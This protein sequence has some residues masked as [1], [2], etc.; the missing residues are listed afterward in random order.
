MNIFRFS[1]VFMLFLV[2]SINVGLASAV[3]ATCQSGCYQVPQLLVEPSGAESKM[4]FANRQLKSSK[5][6]PLKLFTVY[7]YTI[8][9]Q[10]NR[11]YKKRENRLIQKP[12]PI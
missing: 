9:S 10:K 6:K 2:C 1:A 11:F 8:Q 7:V 5:T 12:S 3:M 4:F